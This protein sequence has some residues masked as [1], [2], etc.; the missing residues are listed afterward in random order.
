MPGA[1]FAAGLH[2]GRVA[3]F[4]ARRGLG[5]VADDDGCEYG[6]HATAIA[7]GSRRI[8]EGTVVTFTVAPAHRGRYEARS[9]VP[10]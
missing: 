1:A 8:E 3:S 10:A 5:V 6:F 9:L 4:D 7:D 2:H